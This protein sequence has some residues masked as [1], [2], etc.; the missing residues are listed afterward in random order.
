MTPSTVSSP[1]KWSGPVP[2]TSGASPPPPSSDGRSSVTFAPQL[3]HSTRPEVGVTAC[4]P[5]SAG[6]GAPHS[7]QVWSA[8]AASSL[9]RR[10][11]LAQAALDVD[12]DD[13]ALVLSGAAVVVDRLRRLGGQARR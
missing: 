4:W 12:A 6:S 3:G 2:S 13:V 9:R 5:S 11:R 10:D 7:G 1:A 8:I